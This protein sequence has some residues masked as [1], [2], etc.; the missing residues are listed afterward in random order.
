MSDH[1]DLEAS[2]AEWRER[3]LASGIT[4]PVPLEELESHL[5]DDIEAQMEAGTDAP[6]AFASASARIGPAAELRGEF[7]KANHNQ[8]MKRQ[9]LETLTAIAVIA[10]LIGFLLPPI[11]KWK[12]HQPWNNVDL[13]GFAVGVIIFLAGAAFTAVCALRRPKMRPKA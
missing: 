6:R 11:A 12:A 13:A 10:I 4:T 2:I 7:Q 8:T 9:L 5:R 3:M 1:F